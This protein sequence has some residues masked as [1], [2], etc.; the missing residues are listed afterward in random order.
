MFP[1]ERF[2]SHQLLSRCRS[3]LPLEPG[4]LKGLNFSI[5][6]TLSFIQG[7]QLTGLDNRFVE[8]LFAVNF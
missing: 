4:T 8:C 7:C 3:D 5:S 2:L 1:G 6:K